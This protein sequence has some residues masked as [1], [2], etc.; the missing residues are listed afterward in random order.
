MWSENNGLTA[1]K[2]CSN[3]VGTTEFKLRL[4]NARINQNVLVVSALTVHEV[5]LVSH[6]RIVILISTGQ[7][8]VVVQAWKY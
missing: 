5:R 2:T 8:K 6:L 4:V 1:V 3:N 7:M